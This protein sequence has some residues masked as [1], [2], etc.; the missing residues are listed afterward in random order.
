MT[1]TY[2]AF[3]NTDEGRLRQDAVSQAIRDVEDQSRL[4]RAAIFD[5]WSE[6]FAGSELATLSATMPTGPLTLART[7]TSN[8]TLLAAALHATSH[9]L[10]PGSPTAALASPMRTSLMAAGRIACCLLPETTDERRVNS[11]RVLQQEAE[12]MLRALSAFSKFERLRVAAPD[13]EDVAD[14]NQQVKALR[15]KTGFAA[16][17]EEFALGLLS[18]V[19]GGLFPEDGGARMSAYGEHIVFMFHRFSGLSHAYGWPTMLR[20]S[21]L[22]ADLGIIT[23]LASLSIRR[24]NRAANVTK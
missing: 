1:T 2:F 19:V 11:Y 6:R 18:R 12:S 22:T 20:P 4:L 10:S 7:L 3:D 9:L 15:S 21:E 17:G 8:A 23:S 16:M 24:L 13:D 14:V 5:N